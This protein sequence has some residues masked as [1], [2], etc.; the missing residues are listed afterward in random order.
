MINTHLIKWIE[1]QGSYD[2]DTHKSK[3]VI[4]TANPGGES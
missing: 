1:A 3:L 2:S 4:R